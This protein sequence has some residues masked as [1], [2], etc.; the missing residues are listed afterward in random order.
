MERIGHVSGR[1]SG[2]RL[3]WGLVEQLAKGGDDL[4]HHEGL[5]N[6]H[7]AW[8][9]LRVPFES[10]V[11]AHVDDRHGGN[12]LPDMSRDIP[13]GFPRPEPY[14]GY[15]SRELG[16]LGIEALQRLGHILGADDFKPRLDQVGLDVKQ[17]QGFVFDEQN[18]VR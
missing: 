6:H 10:A 14:I 17:D 18:D 11:A 2:I 16:G 4:G 13:T 1:R 3:D 15:Q 5:L 12:C 7:A 8:N 9:A